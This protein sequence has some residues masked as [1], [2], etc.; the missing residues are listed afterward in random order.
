MSRDADRRRRS[1]VR[2]D[3]VVELLGVGEA[4]HACAASA[5]ASAPVTLPPGTSAFC[6]GD[7]VAD[8]GDRELVGDEPVGVDPDVD[9][10]LEAAD[11]LR[12]RRRRSTRSSCTLD[13]L[14]GQLGQLAQRA[15]A[16]ERDA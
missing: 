3:Q 5:R 6:R 16:G 7:R 8:R 1:H 15:V 13:D 2:D 12:P 4:A 10:P 14:V 11:D 9:R